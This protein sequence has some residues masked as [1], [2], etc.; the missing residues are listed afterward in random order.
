M[1]Q[2]G[3][4]LIER[5]TVSVGSNGDSDSTFT[6]KDSANN[7]LSITGL[8]TATTTIA[9][10]NAPIITSGSIQVRPIGDV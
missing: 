2:Y 1:L 7:A 9:P 10:I 6:I 4:M 8:S 5:A 3:K